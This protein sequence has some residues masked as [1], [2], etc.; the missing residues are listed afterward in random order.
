MKHRRW[1]RPLKTEEVR[2]QIGIAVG[3]LE[4]LSQWT[5]DDTK[6]FGTFKFFAQT[7]FELAMPDDMAEWVEEEE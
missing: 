4:K 3:A 7:A 1:K 5:D 6:E 2:K